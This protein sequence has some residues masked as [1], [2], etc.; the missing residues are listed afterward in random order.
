VRIVGAR[1]ERLYGA[2]GREYIDLCT[3]YGSAWLGHNHPA[4]C[5]ALAT[6]LE[7]YASPGYLPSAALDAVQKAFAS[8]IPES[9]FAGGIYSTG[10]EAVETA[11]RAARVQSGRLDIAGFSGSTHGRSSL[12]AAIG[13]ASPGETQPFVHTL[14]SFA[15]GVEALLA[16]LDELVSRVPLAAIVIEP[17]QMSGGGQE[18]PPALGRRLFALAKKN[19]IALV[20]DETLTGLYRCGARSYWEIAGEAPDI[21]VLGKGLANGFP[22]SAVILRNGF[23]WD[24]ERVR[25]GSTYWNHPL[26]CAAI[27]ATLDE[28]AAMGDAGAKVAAIER[29]V[30]ERLGHLEL[31]GRGAMWCLAAPD[32][33]SQRRFAE[34]ITAAG[35]VV[36]YHDR[37]TRLLP[38]LTIGM[39]ELSRACATIAAAYADTFG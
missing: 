17:I 25:P 28:L 24:R 15:S 27:A 5:R 21:V 9:H 4:V 34:A 19:A 6:Q 38:P 10:M 30:R 33:L 1:N 32:A 22:A 29:V 12:T 11:L 16:S 26:A 14:P 20:F 36:S 39:D 18:M 31:R 37:Y 3:G 35:V 8:F 23:A 13:S 7:T 2:D